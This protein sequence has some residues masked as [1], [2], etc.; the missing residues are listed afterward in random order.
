MRA[1][2]H[3]PLGQHALSSLVKGGGS[4]RF[5]IFLKYKSIFHRRG[6]KAKVFLL[7][8]PLAGAG[9]PLDRV[10]P[11]TPSRLTGYFPRF[12]FPECLAHKSPLGKIRILME[13]MG[14]GPLPR[15][16]WGG[17]RGAPPPVWPSPSKSPPNQTGGVGGQIHPN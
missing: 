2:S 9:E 10:L 6:K 1:P 11:S 17:A 13:M 15:G 16:W 8:S 4:R 3:Y 5:K 7:D 12:T 14:R